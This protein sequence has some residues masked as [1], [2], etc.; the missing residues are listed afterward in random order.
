MK[1]QDVHLESICSDIGR[2]KMK[3]W[4]VSVSVNV[5]FSCEKLWLIFTNPSFMPKLHPHVK[6]VWID[7]PKT[8]T[9]G[10]VLRFKTKKGMP[11]SDHV[12]RCDFPQELVVERRP[13]LFTR[14][15]SRYQFSRLLNGGCQFDIQLEC[16]SPM[17][18]LGK[19]FV[20]PFYR[21]M[22]LA[23]CKR[24]DGIGSQLIKDLP[25]QQ[26]IHQI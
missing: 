4:T 8:L 26:P 11:V 24:L 22:V 17:A 7:A 1:A 19:F 13:F 6:F 21:L 20:K 18:W 12:V 10:S 25:E 16:K 2:L 5:S 14:I 23:F 9:V 15:I 3:S